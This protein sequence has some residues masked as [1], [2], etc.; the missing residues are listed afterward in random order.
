LTKL[1]VAYLEKRHDFILRIEACDATSSSA[2]LQLV[3]SLEKPL[4]G[5]IFMSMVLSDGLFASQTEAGFKR[6]M[7]SKWGALST[8]NGV[9]PIKDLDFFVSFSSVASVFGSTGQSNYSAANSVVDGF[10]SKYSN[11]FSIVLPGISDLGYFARIRDDSPARTKLL[12]WSLTSDQ[13]FDYLGDALLKL[14]DGTRAPLYVPDLNWTN[15]KAVLTS[16]S[17][18]LLTREAT[19]DQTENTNQSSIRG[20]LLTL[21]GVSPADFS[22]QVPFTAYGMDSLSATRLSQ[23]LRPYVTISQMQLLGGMT[24]DQLQAR[25]DATKGAT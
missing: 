3:E 5:A 8:F 13:L 20:K 22:P 12:S 15:A 16:N 1:E 21:L 9:V 24:W 6:V 17:L 19:T 2:T 25:I 7:D 4:G 23:M 14:K 11:A 18:H 10:L